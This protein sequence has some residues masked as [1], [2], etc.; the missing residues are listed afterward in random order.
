MRLS[1]RQLP[2]ACFYALSVI[3]PLT[4][5]P[6]DYSKEAVVI[7]QF[8][9]ELAFAADGTSRF[10]QSAVVRIQSEAG[11]R[12]FGVLNFAYDNENQSV[13]VIYVRVRKPDGSLVPTPAENVQDISSE[14]TR[15]APTY[16]DLREKQVPVKALGIGDTLE[17]KV[18]ITQTKPDIPNQ[19]WFSQ[20][21]LTGVVVLDETLRISTP[22]SVYVKVASPTLKPAISEEA[23]QR[24][25]SWKTTQLEPTPQA[26]EKKKPAPAPPFPSVQLTTFKSWDEL[27]RWYGQLQADRIRVTPAIQAKA[28]ELTKGRTTNT[29]KQRAIYDYVSTKFRYISLSFGVGRYQ[30]HSAQDVLTNQ[31]GDCK[32]KHTLFAS[33]LKAAGI[34]AWAALIG[35]GIKLDPDLPS[36][37]QFNH[38]ITVIPESKEYT[39]L[40]TTPE[41]A[42]YGLLEQSLRDV[43]ALL[44]PNNGPALLVNTPP[45][46]PFLT[47][48]I[49][50]VQ[51]TLSSE[52]TFKGHFDVT[53][54]GETEVVLRTAFHQVPASQWQELVQILVRSVGFAGTVS[55][56]DVDNPESL[57]KPFHYSYDYL[58]ENYSDWANRRISPPFF[59]IPLPFS[60]DEEKP[61]DPIETGGP[62]EITYRASIHLP[63]DFAAQLPD[64]TKA[65]ADF[66]SYTSSYTVTNDVLSA[67][68][69]LL[70]NKA[71][72]PLSG[73]GD[74]LKFAKQ[75]S[76][77]QN[78]LI[79]L[80]ASTP[81]TK[82]G[83][84]ENNPQAEALVRQAA[85]SL[86]TGD[87]NGARYALEQAEHLNPKQL[88]L[89]IDYAT[90]YMLTKQ[91]EKALEAARKEIEYHS[92]SAIAYG[93]VG[94]LQASLG[95]REQAIDALRT[96][97][98][99]SPDDP[100]GVWYLA[101]L[102]NESKRYKEV[103]E[104]VQK[105]L[106]K[107]PDNSRL[108]L[109]LSEALLRDGRKDEGLALVHKIADSSFDGN[110]LNNLAWTLADTS[111]D[112]ML[113]KQYAE[114]SV[115]I[116]ENESKQCS[117]ETLTNQDL[118]RVIALAAA[119]DTLGWVYFRSADMQA[120]EKYIEASWLLSE[121]GDVSDHLGQIYEQQGKHQEAIHSWQLALAADS[122]LEDTRER[123]RK[124]G[125]SADPYRPRLVHRTKASAPVSPAPLT[126]GEELS[127]LRAA[128][129]P[130][131]PKQEGSAEFFVL[132]S[133][134]K[135]EDVQFISGADAL[136]SGGP[137]LL[138]A[139]YDL[140]FPDNG[141]EK[142][143][144]RGILSCSRY[145]SP[146]CEFVMFNP[147]TTRK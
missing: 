145:T 40:D 76:D 77:D 45:A 82:A 83:A 115:S 48:Y 104:L 52:G 87:I 129:V 54:R 43:K 19:F 16:S 100:N 74:Y 3:A 69:R 111:T 142:I 30:A 85:A 132:F 4:A 98:K 60:E 99:L 140:P 49:V 36:P 61:A 6:P 14:V 29:D 7:Q 5:A 116:L 78:Q 62:M 44:I 21:F 2:T 117:L 39:W 138:K 47:S 20:N 139:R 23:G 114:K 22:A 107:T 137:A 73:W 10:E 79:Q 121:R 119:W 35:S 128:M 133:S 146:S 75:V 127:K 68:R 57:D 34:E 90:V 122:K 11:V 28:D 58:R 103:P 32:D 86:R 130:D 51:G 37:A 105:A 97:V 143:A 84:V 136:K 93:A 94:Q 95:H 92:D 27:G 41:V 118:Q 126:P 55:N 26:S 88:G 67:N 113:A 1:P 123:L 50:D 89:W 12:Q 144:R 42:P 64:S 91:P 65:Q 108:Q 81:P 102:L 38:V 8:A 141:P 46:P 109:V 70:V 63:K 71:K 101:S 147:A 125:A 17:Y 96:F 18:R 59:F 53:A 135:V 13:E 124:L 131:L 110:I 112:L 72:L 15:V 9:Q 106:E 33:L 120:A 31:Y 25:Y 24:I 80:A 66:A 56:V 134:G